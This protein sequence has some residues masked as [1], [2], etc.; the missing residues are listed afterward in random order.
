MRHS[1]L[2]LLAGNA[3]LA[4]LYAVITLVIA[5]IGYGAVQFRISELLNFAAWMSPAYIPGIAAGC[6]LANLASPFGLV[7]MIFGT[8]A[9][10]LACTMMSRTKNPWLASL[11]PT[12]FCLFIGLEFLILYGPQW[13]F[14]WETLTI[15]VS[16]FIISTV[17]GVPLL[18][19]LQKRFPWIR[20]GIGPEQMRRGME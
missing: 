11:W 15:M 6:F 17:I 14:A 12:V 16:E 19:L 18:K 13:V 20:K 8:T 5:P 1:A 7:D 4:A 10:I 3:I 9:T 2:K